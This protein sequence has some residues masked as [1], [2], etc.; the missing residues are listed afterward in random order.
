[1][2]LFHQNNNSYIT[3]PQVLDT[4]SQFWRLHSHLNVQS[5]ECDPVPL[6][7]KQDLIRLQK[8][9]SLEEI[10]LL[11]QEMLNTLEYFWMKAVTIKQ[12]VQ[13]LL[14]GE[15]TDFVQGSIS[16]LSQRYVEIEFILK[17]AVATFTAIVPIPTDVLALCQPDPV[18]PSDDFYDTDESSDDDT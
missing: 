4:T 13:E 1:M 9:R 17:Q 10:E 14:Q 16:V 15:Q 8:N 18:C 7:T 6:D 2:L 11:Q 3:L 5:Y 12:K